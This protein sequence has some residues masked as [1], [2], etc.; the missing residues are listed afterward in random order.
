MV[1]KN[2]AFLFVN[3]GRRLACTL[4]RNAHE[5]GT[6]EL[7]SQSLR[8]GERAGHPPPA[9]L[10]PVTVQMNGYC[11]TICPWV[12]TIETLYSG[13]YTGKIHTRMK[14]AHAS[15]P[16]PS[17]KLGPLVLGSGLDRNDKR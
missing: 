5:P 7:K 8:L 12:D 4:G 3:R 16:A 15:P 13:I 2:N 11:C 17:R 14:Y 9:H 10:A 1:L 6:R